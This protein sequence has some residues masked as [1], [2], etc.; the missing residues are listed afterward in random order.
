ML[1][2]MREKIRHHAGVALGFLQGQAAQLAHQPLLGRQLILLVDQLLLQPGICL[3]ARQLGVEP[4]RLAALEFQ[5]GRALRQRPADL[6]LLP[7]VTDT[8]ATG[9]AAAQPHTSAI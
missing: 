6:L 1:L 3:M 7:A 4:L 5:L 9:S 2:R 8:P